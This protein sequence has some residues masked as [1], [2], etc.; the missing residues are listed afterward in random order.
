MTA[1]QLDAL[2]EADARERLTACLAAPEW[3]EAL[4]AGRPHRGA[5]GWLAAADAAFAG[6]TDAAVLAAL[7]AH[8][9]IGQAPS[10]T[11]ADAESSRRE[12]AG[13]TSAA[14]DLKTAISAANRAYEQR[15]DRV[16]LIRAAGRSADEIL[17]E[18][19][20]RLGNDE[21]TELREAREQIRQITTLRLEGVLRG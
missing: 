2:A 16:F 7:A 6:L 17:A 21:S 9:R 4:L 3:V 10:G 13:V 18:V 11:G 15:F 14:D 12:Q 1:E 5:A 8:P 19:Q 20:R